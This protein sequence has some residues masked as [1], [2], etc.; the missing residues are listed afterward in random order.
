MKSHQTVRVCLRALMLITILSCWAQCIAAAETLFTTQV[1]QLLNV[2]NGL[3]TSYEVGARFT[4]GVAGHIDAIRFWKASR[5]T[6]SH[7]GHVWNASGQLLTSVTFLNETASGWQQQYLSNPLAVNA[8]TVYVVSVNTG[9]SYYVSTHY[10]LATKIVHQD[11]STLVGSNGVFGP[12]GRFPSTSSSADSNYFRDVVFSP[13]LAGLTSNPATVNSGNVDV[14]SSS[15]Q[16]LTLTNSTGKSVSISKVAVTG[17][18]FT[19]SAIAVP[20][21]LAPG[22][23]TSLKV[24]FTPTVMGTATGSLAVTSSASNSILTVALSGVGKKPQISVV[25]SSVAF[26]NVP[27]GI[28]N[29]QTLAVSDS[30]NSNL[31]ISQVTVIGTGFTV[32]GPTL[33]ATVTP[34]HSVSLTV[35]FSPGVAGNVTGTLSIASNAT[36]SPITV[37]LTGTGIAQ[38]LQLSPSPSALAFGNIPQGSSTRQNVTLT[39]TGNA[40]VS[41]SKLTPVGS[42]FSISGMAMPVTLAPG[43]SAGFSV[44]FA[45]TTTGTFSGNVSVSSTAPNSPLSIPLSGAGVLSHDV[46]LSWTPSSSNVSGYSV[47]RGGQKGGPYTK[48]TS[49]LVPGTSYS[50]ANVQAGLTYYYVV[51]SVASTGTE[52]ALSSEVSATI[53]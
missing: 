44:T 42:Y 8:N 16:N 33:P 40:S 18:A 41:L 14:G 10:G 3:N 13:A 34:S 7:V 1:P 28:A 24:T 4:A 48:I 37:P 38:T 26:G 53:P 23:Q 11:L 51:T 9:N 32:S 52:S 35:R 27:I 36:H 30:G 25:P 15:S 19:A 6:G 22:S 39:N 43:Q 17:A 2:T 31:L 49:S 20:L 45:P 47:Y 21:S 46:M 29:T 12:A 50:D 5:E